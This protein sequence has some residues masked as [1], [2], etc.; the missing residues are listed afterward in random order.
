[1]LDRSVNI[2]KDTSDYAAVCEEDILKRNWGITSKIEKIPRN[3]QGEKSGQ[4]TA[5]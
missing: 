2:S 1:M 4:D 5:I 3:T